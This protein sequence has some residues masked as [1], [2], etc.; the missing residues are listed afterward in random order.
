MNDLSL[1][2]AQVTAPVD[3][4]MYGRV[5]GSAF[6]ELHPALQAFHSYQ[7]THQFKGAA[8]T[9]APEGF[10]ARLLGRLLGTPCVAQQGP[11]N[12]E[13]QATPTCETWIRNYPQMTMSSTL[14]L[15]AGRVVEQLGAATL[16]F[17]L[18]ADNGALEMKLV[19][20]RF[21]HIPCPK[22]LMP[23]VVAREH[24]EGDMLHFD[25]RADLP[26]IGIVTRYTGSLSVLPIR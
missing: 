25:V 15:V 4:S 17:D 21:F 10:L 20:M 1:P 13:L 26:F 6:Q 9:Y 24:G 2:S 18:H 16:T 11:I 5:M 19:K 22:W 23:R 8:Q 3:V 12:F 14:R 7:G